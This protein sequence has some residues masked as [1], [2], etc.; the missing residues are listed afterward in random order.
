MKVA[1]V[2]AFHEITPELKQ[3]LE[4]VGNQTYQNIVHI[5]ARDGFDL[6]SDW[7]F[8]T[9][10]IPLPNNI[11]DYGD[12]PRSIG[13]LYTKSMGVDAILFLIIGFRQII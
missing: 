3:C 7:V 4:S 12:S 9:L 5:T 1:I 10:N 6:P 13:V 11:N 2:T 8:N